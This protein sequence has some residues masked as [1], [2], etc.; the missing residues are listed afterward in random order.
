MPI[1]LDCPR[2]KHRLSV[3]SRKA[4]DY[5][6]C[7][8]CKGRF[9]VPEAKPAP[10]APP[11]PGPATAQSPAAATPGLSKPAAISAPVAQPPVRSKPEPAPPADN[12]ARMIVPSPSLPG[13]SLPDRPRVAEVPPTQSPPA[14]PPVSA[15]KRVARFI[16]AEAA[17]S[18]LKLAEDGKLP[19][20]RL[21]EAGE[22][23][24]KESRSRG[25][26]PLVLFGLLA[27]SVVASVVLVFAP[28]ESQ[29]PTKLNDKREAQRIIEQ[30]Y[31]G[32][33]SS[34]PAEQYQT[35]LREAYQARLRRDTK[36]ERD[37]YRRVL[38]LLRAERGT[39]EQGLT[40]S[41]QKDRELERLLILLSD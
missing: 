6:T 2:C 26:N 16:T 39:S 7:P 25:M 4:G 14:A 10:A 31:L 33:D 38:G 23:P 11:G 29:S 13:A 35:W 22:A 36:Q 5:A 32:L 1:Q 24:V 19:E 12:V 18:T 8:R 15:P 3:P 41:P 20:L 17:Q 21:R 27:F 34:A 9:W 28:T 40:G 30:D 37:L